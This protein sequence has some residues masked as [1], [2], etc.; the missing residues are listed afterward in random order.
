MSDQELKPQENIE[1]PKE[2]IKEEPNKVGRPPINIDWKEFD[3]LCAIHCT[4]AEIADFFDCSEDTIER[5][6]LEDKKINFAEYYK[7]KTSGGKR[8]LRRVQLEKALNGN[9]TMMIWMGKQLLG[10]TEKQETYLSNNKEG[11]STSPFQLIIN[12]PKD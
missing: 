12:A 8:A 1:Q 11:E 10:Q 3:K 4:L 9:T 7:K 6:V 2:E 5:R